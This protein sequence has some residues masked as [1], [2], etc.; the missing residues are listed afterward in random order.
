MVPYIF[1]VSIA[2]AL[3]NVLYLLNWKKVIRCMSILFDTK[4]YFWISSNLNKNLSF[5]T[6]LLDNITHYV[7][8][9]IF[10][11]SSN[12]NVWKH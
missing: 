8:F 3:K 7:Y 10:D 5:D 12:L 6:I 1:F 11:A 2:F 4:I 9:L